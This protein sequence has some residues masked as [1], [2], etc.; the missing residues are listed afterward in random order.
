[1]SE[2]RL[3][4]RDRELWDR[5]ASTVDDC[6]GP[7]CHN[8]RDG[9]CFMVQARV[10]AREAD[11]LVVNHALLLADADSGGAVLPEFHHL[12]V[13][14]AHHLEEA[15]TQAESRRLGALAILAVVERIP[16]LGDPGLTRA[17]KTVRQLAPSVFADLRHLLGAAAAAEGLAHPGPLPADRRL[18][19]LSL[20]QGA[21]RS[22]VRLLRA[23]E[24][25]VEELRRVGGTPAAQAEL[26]PQ[27][28]NGGQECW[29]AAEALRGMAGT[30]S[31]LLAAAADQGEVAAPDRR[32]CW[33]EV[34][35][36]DRAVLR[37]APVAVA[38]D[39]RSGLFDHCQTLV[40]TSATLAVAGSFRYV[41]ARLGLEGAEELVLDSPFDYLRQ[42]L[43][44]LPQGIP[45]STDPSHTRAV[46]VLVRALALELGGR[47]LV[48]F[49]GYQALREVHQGL[50]ALLSNQGIAVLGQGLDGTRNQ[51]LRN[52]RRNPRSVL[53]GTSSFWE[54][55]DLPGETLQCVVID[56]LPFPVPS[57]PIFQARAG[58]SR[59]SFSELALPEAV[60]KLKQGFGRLVRRHG[61]R[62]AVV[63]CDPRIQERD[64][65]VEFMRAL[66]R[67]TLVSEPLERVPA[68]VGAFMRREAPVAGVS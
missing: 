35:G 60:L 1:R 10:R 43:C 26:W 27:P 57:D 22:L 19:Q 5:V 61:D 30:I 23:L 66:P 39:L 18:E 29:M 14:E 15:A 32:V 4:G 59:D 56:K 6:L 3:A 38:G 68:A 17:L 44:C 12:I 24:R 47:T 49:T 34:E 33:I 42:S 9:R 54:G 7:A 63:I 40:L 11:L 53:L 31:Q 37:S 48:L 2:L 64:Y 25:A 55:I 46:V 58:S 67:A 21:R 36:G 13:D 16:D 65:G 45:P 51:V 41:K 50:R 52:F 28:D 20:W 62:G 8:W